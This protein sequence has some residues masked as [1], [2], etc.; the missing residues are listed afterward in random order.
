M[1]YDVAVVGGGPAGMMASIQAGG[2]GKRVVLVERNP[3]LGKKLLLTGKGRC[4]LT[5]NSPAEDLMEKF[6]RPGLFYRDAFTALSSEGLMDF[7]RSLGLPLKVERQGRVF[8]RDDRA[9]SVLDVLE[10][11]LKKGGI[12]V[13]RGARLTG[14][15]RG[16]ENFVLATEGSGKRVEAKKAVLATGGVS[17]KE[18]GSTGDGLGIA[19]RLGHSV[20]PLKQGLVPLKAK[21]RWVRELMGLSL[22]NVRVEFSLRG[23]KIKTG[24]GECVFTHFGVSGP[25]ILDISARVVDA[26]RGEGSVTAYIDFKPGMSPEMVKKRLIRELDT[27]SSKLKNTLKALLPSKLIPVF[28]RVS[29]VDPD[30][31]CNQVTRDERASMARILKALPL[32]ITGSLPINE[33]MVTMGGVSLKEISPSRMESKRVP[34][35]FF[36]GEIMEGGAPSGGY[37]L[38]QAFST[39]FLAGRSAGGGE[40]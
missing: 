32:T 30:K 35:L 26:L 15:K 10:K 16:G 17:Y 12:D 2:R 31:P 14:I 28:I 40:A 1:I 39:G 34:G 18:T 25:L 23:R 24:I 9:G 8:P 27:G 6:G 7:F 38:H 37:N 19:R 5:N 21:E 3:V 33:A 11:A 4:N 36:A 20:A 13:M 22:R 29:G